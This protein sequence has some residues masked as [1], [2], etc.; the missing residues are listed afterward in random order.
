MRIND[1]SLC[2]INVIPVYTAP[3][4]EDGHLISTVEEREGVQNV[5]LPAL[6][7]Q[8]MTCKETIAEGVR[9]LLTRNGGTG[10]LL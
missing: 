7:S 3:S 1:Q 9:W 5:N 8:L 2:I 4:N 10:M 6:L